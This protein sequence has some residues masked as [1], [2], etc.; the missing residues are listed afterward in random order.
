M[1][2]KENQ[3]KQLVE[4]W[5]NIAALPV[6]RI[7]GIDRGQPVDR[8]YIESFLAAK[9]KW[10]RGDVLEVGSREYTEKFGRGNVSRSLVMSVQEGKHKPDIVANL[11]TGSGIIENIADCF[12]MTQ[13][14]LCIFD[15][16]SAARNALKILKPG[17]IL[18]LTVPGI[19]QISRYDYQRWGQYWSFTDQSVRKLFEPHVFSERIEVSVKSAA[20]FLYGL[21]AHELSQEDLEFNDP[22]YPLIIA[23]VVKK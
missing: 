13:T 15:V 7:F 17:G 23:S 12:I 19:T 14:L 6:S 4:L 9:Q 1:H 2:K 16:C 11:E 20:A 18:L 5:K 3:K 8:Y 22:D 10:I 21:A